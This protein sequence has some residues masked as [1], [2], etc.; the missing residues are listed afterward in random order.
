MARI[1]NASINLAKVGKDKITVTEKRDS[2]RI[3]AAIEDEYQ[4]FL[5]KL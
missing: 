5:S 3:I 1:I 2:D 4:K